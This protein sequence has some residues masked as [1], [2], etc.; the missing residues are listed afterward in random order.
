MN[1]A[2]QT[3]STIVHSCSAVSEQ[4]PRNVTS[5]ALPGSAIPGF[6][7]GVS[8]QIT[9]HSSLWNGTLIL[10]R[11]VLSVS[12]SLVTIALVSVSGL[13]ALHWHSLIL[14]LIPSEA[15]ISGS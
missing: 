13:N 7:I 10:P 4:M 3:I 11:E 2:L 9:L 8:T 1:L 14:V 6:V 5:R 12:T 15:W